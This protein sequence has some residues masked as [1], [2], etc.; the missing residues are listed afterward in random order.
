MGLSNCLSKYVGTW[1]TPPRNKAFNIQA[2]KYHLNKM[3]HDEDYL[4]IQFESGTILRVHNW[5]F[6]HVIEM[7][8]KA[9]KQYITVGTRINP[10][11]ADTIQGSLYNEAIKNNYG[12]ANLRIASYVCDMIVLCGYAEYGYTTNPHTDRTVQGIRKT[13]KLT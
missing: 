13:D 3:N 5:R 8:R 7:L 1:I 11:H 12:Y 6:N 4:E 10:E 9:G 2:Q